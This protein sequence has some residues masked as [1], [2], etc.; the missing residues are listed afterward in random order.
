MK[1]DP[2]S[3]VEDFTDF[4]DKEI[5]K[6]LAEHIDGMKQYKG[7]TRSKMRQSKNTNCVNPGAEYT[8]DASDSQDDVEI[9]SAYLESPYSQGVLIV[10]CPKRS[11]SRSKIPRAQY[12]AM[13]FGCLPE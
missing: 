9:D 10:D 8:G 6:H 5:A 4:P 3:S 2:E 11:K 7:P 12:G 1:F 13:Q